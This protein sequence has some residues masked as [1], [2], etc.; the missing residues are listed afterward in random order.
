MYWNL[1]VHKW[2]KIERHFPKFDNV[3]GRIVFPQNSFIESLIPSA[4]E[5]DYIWR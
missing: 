3:A 4:S 5:Y 2:K 1:S